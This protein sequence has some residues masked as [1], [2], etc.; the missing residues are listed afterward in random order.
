[1]RKHLAKQQHLEQIARELPYNQYAAD[2]GLEQPV[3]VMNKI[4]NYV[5]MRADAAIVTAPQV[6][7]VLATINEG[8]PD[9]GFSVDQ[10][11]NVLNGRVAKLV[12]DA[13]VGPRD[14]TSS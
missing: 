8:S 12:F 3:Q 2:I 11:G 6:T 5:G 10:E 9:L 1:M 4:G 7:F 13:W 14:E